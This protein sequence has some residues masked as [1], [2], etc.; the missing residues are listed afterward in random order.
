MRHFLRIAEGLDVL[1]LVQS[2]HRQPELWNQHSIRK[3]TPGTPHS[4]MN[5]I[6]LRYAASEAEFCKPHFAS[7]YP[8][9]NA[10][11]HARQFIF[12]LMARVEATHLGG[13][14]ITRIPPGGKIEAHTDRGWHPEFYNCKLYV[15]LRSNPDCIFRVEDERVAMAPGEVW[16]IDNTKEHDVIN[17][18]DSERMTL[19]ICARCE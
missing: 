8:A 19:I 15:V 5:D 12:G 6:W 2:I 10:L 13:V 14:L 4:Q 3:L 7:W 1:P 18:G 11:P 9:F 16:Q 17:G